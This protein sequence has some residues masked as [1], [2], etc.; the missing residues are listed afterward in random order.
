MKNNVIAVVVTY[1][2]KKL[3]LECIK[4]LKSQ[5]YKC[6]ILIVNN[7]STDDTEETILKLQNKNLLYA[8][9]GKNIGGAGGF[10]FGIKL[11]VENYDYKYVWLMDDDTIPNETSLQELIKAKELLNND[12]GFLASK[13]L[14]IDGS[15][16]YMNN[17]GFESKKWMEDA[18]LIEY[19][20][21]RIRSSSFVSCFI[22]TDVVREV[23]LP[24]KDFFIWD[25]D[26][27]YTSRITEVFNYKRILC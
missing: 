13:P 18:N 27:E 22:K 2:R 20:L 21:F 1:N 12:F 10:N 11:V 15:Y 26:T 17:V 24:I 3:L 9:T 16:C 7:A 19:G 8:N 25:D 14:W 23:G 5:S 6:D 4:A